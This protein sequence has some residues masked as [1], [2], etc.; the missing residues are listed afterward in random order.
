[1]K[2][3]LTEVTPNPYNKTI[4]EESLQATSIADLAANIELRGMRYPIVVTKVGKVIIDGERRWLA[5][6][7]LKWKT[8]DV[9]EED[10]DRDE[11]L[12][13]VLE[14]ATSQRQMTLIEQAR[15][16]N[17]YYE[18][19]RKVRDR[20]SMSVLEAK[21]L[22]IKRAGLPFRAVGLADQLV[23]IVNRGDPELHEKLLS[24]G[25]SISALY[26][27]L[28]RRS[29]GRPALDNPPAPIRLDVP[30]EKPEPSPQ[31]REARR[32]QSLARKLEREEQREE[33]AFT[34]RYVEAHQDELREKEAR[35]KLVNLYEPDPPPAA[36][37]FPENDETRVIAEAFESLAIREPPEQL[38]GRLTAFMEDIIL[39]VKEVDEQRAREI[40]KGVVKPMAL[41]LSAAF[42][43]ET[44]E[45]P[46]DS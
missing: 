20:N 3:R 7:K 10:I 42:P 17:A 22:A 25:T 35:Q 33:R 13:R 4:F 15:I 2:L 18:H 28:E 27:K 36:K 38:V 23:Q 11:I 40:V 34:E 1:M 16:Y 37:K 5:A 26:D 12:D 45:V 44:F 31:Q 41:R 6:K 39:K 24:G 14:A 19:L 8:I 32:A 30:P 29:Y 21:K 46:V 43:R 9:I